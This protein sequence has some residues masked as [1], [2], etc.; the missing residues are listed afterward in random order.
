M[1]REQT[2]RNTGMPCLPWTISMKAHGWWG[3]QS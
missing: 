2:V 3:W 1:S